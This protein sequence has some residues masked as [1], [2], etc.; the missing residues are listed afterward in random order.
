[1]ICIGASGI[2]L[3]LETWLT[4]V[5]VAAMPGSAMPHQGKLWF[6]NS[7]EC[8]TKTS[9]NAVWSLSETSEN[10]NMRFRAN[11]AELPPYSF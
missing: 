3:Q 9:M 11:G 4:R 2:S 1:M 10:C 7:V 5:S 6:Q 8:M